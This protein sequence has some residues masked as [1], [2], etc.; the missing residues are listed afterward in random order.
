MNI[1]Q[2][3]DYYQPQGGTEQYVISISRY[4][5]KL[6]HSISVLYGIR[7]V[8]TL[9]SR[10]RTEYYL[11]SIPDRRGL[12]DLSSA[13]RI[14]EIVRASNSDIAY[15]HNVRN[16]GVIEELADLLPTLRFV[17]DHRLFC[18]KGDK[19]FLLDGN[20]CKRAC[21]ARCL[22]NSYWRG[23]LIPLP[24]I[25]LS[26]IREKLNAIRI[27]RQIRLIVASEYMKRCLLYNGFSP[28]SIEVVPYFCNF[29]DSVEPDFG[30]FVFFA[31]RLIPQKGLPYLIRSI[32]FWPQDLRLVVAGDGPDL[33]RMIGLAKKMRVRERID[34]LGE[35]SNSVIQRYYQD[36]LL[37]AV[38]SIWDEPFG[39]VGLEAMFCG[40]PVVAF[41]VGG[42]SD[43][44]CDGMNGFLIRAK[45]HRGLAKRISFLFHNKKVALEMGKKGSEIYANRFSREKHVT[46][47]LS[48]FNDEVQKWRV[49]GNQAN[50]L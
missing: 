19:M 38:P 27:H 7:T 1:L 5:E 23:C 39:T 24:H 46:R 13:D 50:A 48:L 45:D 40:K 6:G 47:L 29:S 34:F 8:H 25:L 20:T 35:V 10:N 32:P 28:S 11:P 2:V 41:G 21:G 4:L 22:I 17:H 36:C 16:Y 9:C 49:P 33:N 44:L 43:W 26:R 12:L 31:G 37:V 18:P 15:V 3:C 42:I 14:K 30:D